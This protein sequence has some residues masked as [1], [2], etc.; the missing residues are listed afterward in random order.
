MLAMSCYNIINHKVMIVIVTKIYLYSLLL[1]HCLLLLLLSL[2]LL[3][4][5]LLFIKINNNL[6]TYNAMLLL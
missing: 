5:M 3:S 6:I 2:L 4:F 1:F